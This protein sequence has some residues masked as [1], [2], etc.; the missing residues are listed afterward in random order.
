MSQ[1]SSIWKGSEIDSAIGVIRHSGVTS[2]QLSVLKGVVAGVVDPGKALVSSDTKTLGTFN[3]LVS[4][5]ITCDITN[6]LNLSQDP[7][8]SPS[9]GRF[10]L[11]MKNGEL[12]TKNSSGVV[13]KIGGGRE[14]E[15]LFTSAVTV[16]CNHSFGKKYVGVDVIGLDDKPILSQIQYFDENTVLVSF[17]HSQSG[18]VII[19][20]V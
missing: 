2:A 15:F 3:D 9:S 18:R 5:V 12:H 6:L 19:R 8:G 20:T 11:Y 14:K 10:F 13:S 7:V 1:F 17:N 4:T 16:T